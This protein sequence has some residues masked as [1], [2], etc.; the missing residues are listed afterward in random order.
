MNDVVDAGSLDLARPLTLQPGD[1]EKISTAFLK[2]CI[3][4]IEDILPRQYFLVYKHM[5]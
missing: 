3:T 5:S 2:V 1:T 4:K